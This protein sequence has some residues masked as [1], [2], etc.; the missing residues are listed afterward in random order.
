MAFGIAGLVQNISDSVV[1]LVNLITGKEPPKGAGTYPTDFSG[2]VLNDIDPSKWN[3]SVPYTFSVASTTSPGNPVGGFSDFPLPINPSELN[4]DETFAIS[5]RPTQGGTTIQQGGNRYGDLVIA[6]TTG[7]A[8]FRGAGGVRAKNGKA[9]FQPEELK[10]KSGYEVF[11]T[12]RN[13]FK[14]YYQYKHTATTPEGKSARLIFKNFKDGEFLIVE[15]LKFSLKRSAGRPFLY[16]YTLNFKILG[17]VALAKDENKPA[18]NFLSAIDD[19]VNEA[20][21]I[22]DQ[23][24]G[25]FLRSQDIL[26]QVEAGYETSVLGPLRTASLAM[27]ALVGVPATLSD[28]SNKA[29]TNTISAAASV[30]IVNKL[31]EKQASGKLDGSNAGLQATKLPNNTKNTVAGGGGSNF[32]VTLSQKGDALTF[33]DPGDL[34]EDALNALSAE[35]QAALETPRAFYENAIAEL[36]RVRDNA[37]DK[38]NLGDP[39]YNAQS[40]RVSTTIVDPGKVV[41]DKEYLMLAAFDQAIAGLNLLLSTN[42]LFK[43]P[44]DQRIARVQAAFPEGLDDVQAEQAV[45]EMV[46][47]ANTDLERLALNE[48]GSASRWVEI[49]ELNDLKPPFVVQ[50]RSDTSENVLHPGDMVLIPKPVVNGFGTTPTVTENELNKDL[51][52]VERNLGIDFKMTENFDLDLGNRGELNIVKSAENVA[53][54][55]ILKLAIEKGELLEHPLL[56]VG[57]FVGSKGQ[58][59]QIV[60]QSILESLSADPRF[61]SVQNLQL[62][63]EGPELTVNFTVKI[64]NVDTPVPISLKL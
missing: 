61:E 52:A 27:K 59:L 49:V 20:L 45:K 32:L 2:N 37:A 30:G 57:L 12:L 60:S 22:V 15:L 51:N 55:I 24:R 53:Q 23:A 16:D 48:L 8:P 9:I 42:A 62:L 28:M 46:M 13:W 4:Q 10:Y 6:G 21:D 50:D 26:R 34:P 63:R 14:A 36:I 54:A 58:D 40:E 17:R 35:Q 43:S 11:H 38:Y 19:V 3:K 44:Y 31:K 29:L 1:G 64:K 5:I 39:I 47:P 25:T 7:V 41:T 56:G 18:S 33:V